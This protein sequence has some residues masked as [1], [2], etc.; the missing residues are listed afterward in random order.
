MLI[1][2]AALLLTAAGYAVLCAVQPFTV[3][4]KC[5]G[6]GVRQTSRRGVKLCRRCK[7]TRYRLRIGR[8][9]H[10]SG[11]RVHAAGTRTHRP[12]L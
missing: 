11:H 2:S 12:N 10:N 7:G 3:C 8:R 4:R 9:L 6:T 5:T 1:A